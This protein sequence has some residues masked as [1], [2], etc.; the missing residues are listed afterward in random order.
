MAPPSP[1]ARLAD[2]IE[3]VALIRREMEGVTL[4]AF[5]QDMRKRWMVE[6]GIEIISEASRRLPDDLKAR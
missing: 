6:R 5:E 2:I 4:H 1:I 3:A